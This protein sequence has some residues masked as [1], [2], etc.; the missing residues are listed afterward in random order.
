MKRVDKPLI[1]VWTWLSVEPTRMQLAVMLIAALVM[2]ALAV[3]ASSGQ[4]VPITGPASGG[5]GGSG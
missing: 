1:A 3:L 4:P 2:I 5:S